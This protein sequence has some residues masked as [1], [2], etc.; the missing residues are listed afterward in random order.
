[1]AVV[2]VYRNAQRRWAMELREADSARLFFPFISEST[3]K[4]VLRDAE[5]EST[6]IYTVVS[7]SNFARGASSLKAIRWLCQSGFPVYHL[8]DLHAKLMVVPG[9]FASVGSQNLTVAGANRLEA[10]VGLFDERLVARV[11]ELVS[12][13]TLDSSEVTIELLDLIEERITPVRRK[14]AEAYRAAEEVLAEVDS[15]LR[16]R[17]EARERARGALMRTLRAAKTANRYATGE[18]TT[19][20]DPNFERFSLA[21]RDYPPGFTTWEIDGEV[22]ELD[23]LY[24]YPLVSVDDGR[25]GWAR[26]AKTRITFVADGILHSASFVLDGVRYQISLDAP[27]EDTGQVN[28][29]ATVSAYGA[30]RL[31]SVEARLTLADVEL[32]DMSVPEPTYDGARRRLEPLLAYLEER[33]TE[34]SEH[35]RRAALAPFTYKRRL[36][37]VAA[38]LFFGRGVFWIR[39]YHIGDFLVL[40]TGRGWRPPPEADSA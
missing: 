10:S 1:M 29:V 25:F 27:R 18:V 33:P 35:V 4:A 19:A 32:G 20:L 23:R 5:P 8:S 37:G 11:E 17:E 3:V 12:G 24:R 40:A 39:P 6:K 26:V 34:F 15:E 28:L 7:I 22:V 2:R 31:I 30:P 21:C 13:W 16:A 36:N 38:D 9:R 14:Y